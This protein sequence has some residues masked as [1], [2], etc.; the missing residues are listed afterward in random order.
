VTHSA[1]SG[2]SGPDVKHFL[3]GARI[4][5]AIYDKCLK[6]PAVFL[7]L[8]FAGYAGN[9]DAQVAVPP[10]KVI[11]IYNNSPTDTIYP[12]LAAYSG[13]V[14]L[15]LQAQFNVPDVQTQTFCNSSP[16]LFTP[17]PE[18]GAGTGKP[19]ILF[20]AYIN[21]DKGVLPGES[22]SITVPFFT[23]LTA[24][25]PATIGTQSSQYI[26]W[27]N[28]QRIFFYDGETAISG[29]YNYNVDSTG[30]I[31]PPTPVNPIAGAAAPSCA[32]DNMF[33][34]EPVTLV[35]YIGVYPTGSIPFQLGE[36]TFA[37]AEGPPPG[38]LL[39]AKSPLSINLKTVNFNISAVDGIYLPVAMAVLGN[40]DPEQSKYLGT[41][42]S[43]ETV[44]TL[45]GTFSGDGAKWPYYYPSYFSKAQPTIPHTTPQDGDSPYNLPSIPSANVVFA[46]SYKVPAPAPPV[47]SSN[48]NGTPML[49]TS[50]QA[51]VTLW[52]RCTTT[53]DM[54]ATCTKIKNVFDFFSRNYRETCGL[55]PTLPDTPTFLTQVYGWAEFAGCSKALVN[56]PGYD[57]A[58]SDFCELQYDYLTETDPAELFNPY[59]QEIHKTLGTNAYAFS[60][61]DKAAF[62]SVPGDGLIITIGGPKGL[63]NKNQVP[64][65]TVDTIHKYCH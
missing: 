48:T 31:V 8:L 53:N 37:A 10:T 50:A 29:A 3:I 51:M 1:D 33:N 47:L 59:T 41:V 62:K 26:D 22:V 49:G 35:S 19:P 18:G 23:Q 6:S 61:D 32:P 9:A 39:P 36:Y 14:D 55:G 60:I 27:W 65:P 12:V 2:L 30:K 28:A 42:K 43:V 15:W 24:T 17:C 25:T 21:P 58:I 16:F 64:L 52:T 20:R 34:C 57:A 40:S 46:E 45:L 13:N 54:S 5:L 44:R 4:V 56:T 7:L 63:V 38:G 11:T